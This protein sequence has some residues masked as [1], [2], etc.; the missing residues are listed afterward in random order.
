MKNYGNQN[1]PV[2]FII[3]PV[4]D[5]NER[6]DAYQKIKAMQPSDGDKITLIIIFNK[7]KRNM[8]DSPIKGKDY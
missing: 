1:T 4:H 7:G 3:E 2:S 5:Y 8:P 6:K